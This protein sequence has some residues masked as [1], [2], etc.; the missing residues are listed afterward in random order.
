M[1]HALPLLLV[2]LLGCST[3]PPR[4]LIVRAGRVID[5]SGA[6]AKERVR[7]LITDGVIEAIDTDD[8]RPLLADATVIDATGLSVLPGL[9][10]P[11]A[12]LVPLGAGDSK[13]APSPIQAAHNL[14]ALLRSGITSVADFGAPAPLAIALRQHVGT[15]RNRG[16][17]VF[18]AGPL[19]TA[20][21]IPPIDFLGRAAVA[22]G[23]AREVAN[24]EAATLAVREL[25]VL[26][27][28]FVAVDLEE[29]RP[30][31]FLSPMLS[32]EVLCGIVKEARRQKLRVLAQ[33]STRAAYDEAAACG[34]DAL[35]HD[36][37][38]PIGHTPPLE[39]LKRLH[40]TGL[41]PLEAL[42][43]ATQENARILSLQDAVG[44]V[45]TGYRADIVGV[46]GRPDADLDNLTQVEL[47]IVDGV[48]QRLDA[49]SLG[50]ELELLWRLAWAWILS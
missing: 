12:R 18:V 2:P 13:P 36:S 28:D 29:Y 23:M 6:P 11:H 14:H 19:L 7:I 50:E 43:L 16:P 35:T 33:A 27:V 8:E 47:V 34:V 24:P 42:T 3:P 21:S 15:A 17:R 31:G 9:T 46:F 48:V 1:K 10:S 30:N 37:L 26:G 49:P 5:G 39:E 41:T 22:S 4:T 40:E 25:A 44:Q 38:D 45:R 32:E 20:S